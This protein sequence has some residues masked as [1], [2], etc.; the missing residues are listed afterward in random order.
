MAEHQHVHR[1]YHHIVQ[2]SE[3]EVPFWQVCAALL[4]VMF[5]VAFGAAVAT[6]NLLIFAVLVL[7]YL[8]IPAAVAA[9]IIFGIRRL[10]ALAEERIMR[11]SRLA[12]DANSQHRQVMSGDDAGMYGNYPPAC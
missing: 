12:S 11:W 9:G 5:V 2:A 6:G 3:P 1:H 10:I 8:V 7:Y 4:V